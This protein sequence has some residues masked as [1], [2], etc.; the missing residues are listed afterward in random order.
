[1]VSGAQVT[2]GGLEV[3]GNG[4]GGKACTKLITERQ[5]CYTHGCVFRILRPYWLKEKGSKNCRT[6]RKSPPTIEKGSSRGS[7]GG[8]SKKDVIRRAQT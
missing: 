1:M 8:Y 4:M 2:A 5:D 6:L 3:K 7:G